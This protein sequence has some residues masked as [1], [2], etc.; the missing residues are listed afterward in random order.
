MNP[1]YLQVWM[2]LGVSTDIFVDKLYP[3]HGYYGGTAYKFPTSLYYFASARRTNLGHS[4]M[5]PFAYRC[6]LWVKFQQRV[7]T[8]LARHNYFIKGAKGTLTER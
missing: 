8:E 4:Q 1:M 2:A 7:P 6:E 5:L 3:L